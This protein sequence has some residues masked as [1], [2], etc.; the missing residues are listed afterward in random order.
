M[1]TLMSTT[2]KFGR[3]WKWIGIFALSFLVRAVVAVRFV[4]ARAEP[5][6]RARIIETLSARFDGRVELASFDVSVRNGIE[7]YGTG[8]KIF[9]ARILT[10]TSPE[11]RR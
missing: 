3:A 11:C 7:V 8:L 9:G 6:V 5:I 2:R 1:R 4:I 10:L